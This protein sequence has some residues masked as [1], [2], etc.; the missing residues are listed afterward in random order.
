FRSCVGVFGLFVHGPTFMGN[1]LACAVAVAS[2]NLLL[3]S[4]WQGRIREIE[5]QLKRELEPAR[6]ADSVVDVRILGAVGVVEM[7]E[8]V[9]MASLQKFF[10]DQGVWIRPFNKLIYLMPPYIIRSKDLSVLTGAVLKA[11]DFLSH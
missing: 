5:Q 8:P 2:I 4:N 7:R 10:V 11:V 1:P 6:K 3:Q 9:D